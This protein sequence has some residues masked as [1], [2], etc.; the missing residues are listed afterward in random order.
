MVQGSEQASTALR[1][2]RRQWP[3]IELIAAGIASA[4]EKEDAKLD[5]PWRKRKTRDFKKWSGRW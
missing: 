5:R 2:S 1:C 4:G 3:D